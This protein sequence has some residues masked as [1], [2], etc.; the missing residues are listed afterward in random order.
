MGPRS[1]RPSLP[2]PQGEGRQG[3]GRGQGTVPRRPPG[4][5]GALSGGPGGPRERWGPRARKGLRGGAAEAA[6]AALLAQEEQG[7]GAES[8][9]RRAGKSETRQAVGGWEGIRGVGGLVR[10]WVTGE[11]S[12]SLESG[13]RLPARA[14]AAARAPPHLPRLLG[15]RPGVFAAR[16]GRGAGGG[17][18]AEGARAAPPP[19][20]R[21]PLPR[22]PRAGRNRGEVTLA[23]RDGES[24]RDT[25]PRRP[26]PAQRAHP[27][28]RFGRLPCATPRRALESLLGTRGTRPAGSKAYSL[29]R[30]GPRF[31][32][33]SFPFA[34]GAIQEVELGDGI[35]GETPGI[36]REENAA[37][38]G[39]LGK[40]TW[41]AG[42]QQG[43][44]SRSCKLDALELTGVLTSWASW[45][46]VDTPMGRG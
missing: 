46:Q 45:A 4:A 17:R 10:T 18:S 16:P 34:I 5:S 13:A 14:P 40:P 36:G 31:K 28:G 26:P 32:M 27:R 42:G 44:I 24:P 29:E 2:Q 30:R 21:L 25:P 33:R 8:S 37:T 38:L 7:P 41:W 9:P 43:G 20:L 35:M 3:E 39:G 11:G 19:G 12:W 15:P 23:R 22:C 6:R 1:L